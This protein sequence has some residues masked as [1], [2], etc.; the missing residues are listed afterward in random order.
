MY[1]LSTEALRLRITCTQALEKGKIF[2][3]LSFSRIKWH[4]K[5]SSN[6]LG[7]NC[8]AIMYPEGSSVNLEVF[9]SRINLYLFSGFSHM[10]SWNSFFVKRN[11]HT[12]F[13]LWFCSLFV[14]ILGYSSNFKKTNLLALSPTAFWGT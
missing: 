14:D 13:K 3:N 1:N 12:L 11:L 4:R 9:I 7:K 6:D 8:Q 10:W 5:L 2:H